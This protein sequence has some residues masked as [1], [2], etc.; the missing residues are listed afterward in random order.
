MK[1]KRMVA[2]VLSMVI[3]NAGSVS[4]AETG[5]ATASTDLVADLLQKRHSGYEYD[6]AR[7]VTSDQIQ[8]IIRAG[9]LAPSSYNDQPW[10]FIVCDRTTN[11]AAYNKALATLVASNQE[12]AKDAP[13]LIVSVA[14]TNSRKGAFNRWAQYDAGAA[15][16]SMM[17][18]ATSLGLMAHQMGGFD[19]DKLR[20]AF[21]IS[22]DYVPMAVMAVG[23]EAADAP[24][25]SEKA[26][27]PISENFFMGSW[28]SPK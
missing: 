13:L 8:A 6:S 2:G 1:I 9:Q 7:S 16:F 21:G 20:K 12:W 26:R 17:L 25:M 24:A 4:G 5:K 10:C 22:K 27:K 3:L 18:Q 14:S 23:Y 19:E 11:P 28:N 15:A